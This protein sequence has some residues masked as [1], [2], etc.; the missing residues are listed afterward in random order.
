VTIQPTGQSSFVTCSTANSIASVKQV[1]PK[2]PFYQS[3]EI[4]YVEELVVE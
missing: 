2:L 4:S 3:T 1:L